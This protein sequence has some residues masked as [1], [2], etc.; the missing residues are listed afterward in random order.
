[1][2]KRG[3]RRGKVNN[4][5]VIYK[6][7]RHLERAMDCEELDT[8]FLL[9]DCLGISEQRRVSILEIVAK[10]GLAEG[11]DIKRSVNGDCIISL[12]CP[13]IT[14]KGLEYL[15]ENSMMKKAAREAKGIAEII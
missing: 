10:E 7:L 2:I 15:K 3:Q 12:S 14:L 13:R 9:A 8:D 4:F 5:R 11:I 6:I 1:M